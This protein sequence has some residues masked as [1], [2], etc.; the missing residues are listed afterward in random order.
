MRIT[1]TVRLLMNVL[2]GEREEEEEEQAMK[3]T[4]DMQQSVSFL[5]FYQDRRRNA[6]DY[7]S[8]H[9]HTHTSR[10]QMVYS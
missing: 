5:L 7:H 10:H 9:T 1:M 6:H 8:I 2:M 4:S 3:T